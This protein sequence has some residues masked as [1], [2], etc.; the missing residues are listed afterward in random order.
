MRKGDD[1]DDDEMM[2]YSNPRWETCGCIAT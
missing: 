1:D 2:I